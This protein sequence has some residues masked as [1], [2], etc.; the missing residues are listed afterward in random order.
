MPR[1]STRQIGG[2]VVV[3]LLVLFV[4]FNLDE[5]RIWFFGIRL[6]SPIAVVVLLSAGL[7]AG[8]TWLLTRLRSKK[9]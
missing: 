1:M 7:G 5:A 3:T 8:A 9:S 4:V 6:Q 2:W